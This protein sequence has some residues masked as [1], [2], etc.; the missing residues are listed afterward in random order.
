MGVKTD[1]RR[2]EV[3]RMGRDADMRRSSEL[4]KIRSIAES[5]DATS[6]TAPTS[7]VDVIDNFEAL[8]R[9]HGSAV[10]RYA[11]KCVGRREIAEEIASEAFLLLYREARR[12]DSGRLPAWLFTVVR[13][14]AMSH[15]R[16]AVVEQKN[17]T[18]LVTHPQA[19]EPGLLNSILGIPELKPIHRTCLILRYVHDMDRSEIATRLALTDNQVKSCLQYGL[20]LLRSH[21]EGNP[22]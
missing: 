4:P 15:W 22:K 12:I 11:V 10:L 8:Y 3:P 14:L 17:A 1:A 16:K 21:F 2:A 6:S 7:R 18:Q 5:R 9:R 19:S 20:E 13:N